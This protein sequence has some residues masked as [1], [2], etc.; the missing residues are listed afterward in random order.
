MRSDYLAKPAQYLMVDQTCSRFMMKIT[1][2]FS[3]KPTVN[4]M[5]QFPHALAEKVNSCSHVRVG[6][7]PVDLRA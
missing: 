7:P 5:R 4:Q 1:V 2:L 6:K 3:I